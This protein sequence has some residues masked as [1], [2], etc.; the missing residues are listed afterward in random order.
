MLVRG[1]VTVAGIVLLLNAGP[2]AVGQDDRPVVSLLLTKASAEF[3]EQ[4]TLFKC[5]AILENV[6]GK[7]L[8]VR[9]NFFS[10]FDGLELVVTAPD[11][12]VLAQKAY[13]WHQS[14]YELGRKLALKPGRTEG[15]LRFP[16]SAK[17]LSRDLKA[18]KVRLVGTLPGS[19]YERL[20]STETLEVRIK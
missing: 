6:A 9:T 15:E 17:D 5:T 20:L 4:D 3:V 16:I 2:A 13:V 14:P 1:I 7:E 8:T 12:K 18:V 11:G 19:E 10:V